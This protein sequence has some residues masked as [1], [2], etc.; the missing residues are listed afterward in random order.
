MSSHYL[1]AVLGAY[2]ES[3]FA[4][5]PV[6]GMAVHPERTAE[7]PPLTRFPAAVNDGWSTVERLHNQACKYCQKLISM[8]WRFGPAAAV[9][10]GLIAEAADPEAYPDRLAM[11]SFRKWGGAKWVH[12]LAESGAVRT[13]ASRLNRNLSAVDTIEAQARILSSGVAVAVR[14]E[15][16]SA[17]RQ[18]S[19]FHLACSRA[20]GH[21]AANLVEDEQGLLV[22]VAEASPPF[23]GNGKMQVDVF[24]GG[25]ALQAQIQL[26]PETPADAARRG[27][28]VFGRFRD[29][30]FLLDGCVLVACLDDQTAVRVRDARQAARTGILSAA[31]AGARQKLLHWMAEQ[32]DDL[33]AAIRV[34]GNAASSLA[35]IPTP[36]P[37][38]AP[39]MLAGPRPP[40]NIFRVGTTAELEF[41]PTADGAI[42]RF[43][44]VDDQRPPLVYLVPTDAPAIA[45]RR[46]QPDWD[47]W[48]NCWYFRLE[49]APED[50]CLVVTPDFGG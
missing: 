42:A 33:A 37:A 47:E 4:D 16:E 9:L 38:G 50:Y 27:R 20:G 26:A 7:C 24:S 40:A 22:A 8:Q 3:E 23:S 12:W 13:L 34:V 30:Q 48:E 35:L 44:S 5:P 28:H 32:R 2:F 46:L 29:F 6:S 41:C 10:R 49:G 18:D 36:A 17:A 14:P 25:Q 19:R 39:D 45:S 31:G 43:R 21:R 1:P 11:E 15:A